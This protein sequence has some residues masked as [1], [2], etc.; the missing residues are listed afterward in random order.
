M[1]ETPALLTIRTSMRRPDETQIAAFQDVPTGFV[2]DALMGG[3]ALS[4]YRSHR[5]GSRRISGNDELGFWRA[6]G[7]VSRQ[8]FV[9]TQ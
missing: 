5:C 4:H 2:V 9:N 8:P 3:G 7:N 6:T 1:I